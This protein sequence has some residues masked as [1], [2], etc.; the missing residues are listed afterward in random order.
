MVIPNHPPLLSPLYFLDL[1]KDLFW[2][3]EFEVL[4]AIFKNQTQLSPY[5]LLDPM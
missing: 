4:I 3:L 1:H 5:P 2:W